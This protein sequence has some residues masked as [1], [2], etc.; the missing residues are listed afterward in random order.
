MLKSPFPDNNMQYS[1]LHCSIIQSNA[2]QRNTMKCSALN[3]N[4]LQCCALQKP[5]VQFDAVIV[6]C[7]WYQ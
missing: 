4:T 6:G 2:V 5:A 3:Y 1:T 7:G